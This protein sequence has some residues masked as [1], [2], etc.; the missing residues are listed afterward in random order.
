[1]DIAQLIAIYLDPESSKTLAR[2]NLF[3][4][5]VVEARIWRTISVTSG[6]QAHSRKCD[7]LTWDP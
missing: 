3:W 6:E 2:V 4:Q 1:M 7:D 5:K